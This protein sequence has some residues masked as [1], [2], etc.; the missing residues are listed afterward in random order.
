M[1]SQKAIESLGYYVYY[2]K[3]PILKEVFYVG[4]GRG[5]RVFNHVQCALENE[6]RNDKT[7][8]IRDIIKSGYEVEHFVLRHGLTEA[9]ALEIEAA[10]IDFL[11]LVNLYN[12]VS[13]HGSTDRGLMTSEE[14]EQQ[15]NAKPLE[16]KLPVLLIHINRLY[17]RDMTE[18]EL[19]EAT[20]KAWKVGERREKADYAAPVYRG[21][22]REI[23]VI[24]SWQRSSEGK[25]R[26][27]F[28]GKPAGEEIRD[29]F[30]GHSVG[31]NY[32]R[33][34]GTQNP[35]QYINC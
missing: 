14:I 32:G 1:F 4:K 28:V 15:Y 12:E 35:I 2:L 33:K 18:E 19:Y 3:D 9:T 17:R 6:T 31:A 11:G 8:R 26:W 16:T 21:L 24:E 30:I 20:R 27:E 13:G 29:Q 22:V 25:G 23:Y 7:A 10:M 5:N 34:Q